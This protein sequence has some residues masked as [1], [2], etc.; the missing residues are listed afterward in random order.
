MKAVIY[1]R[2]STLLKQDP[3]HQLIPARELVNHRGYELVKEYT[4]RISGSSDKRE[5]LDQLI[6]DARSGK[7]KIVVIYALDRIARDTRF[8]LNLIHEL[9]SY[10]VSLISLRESIDLSTPIGRA[11]LQILGSI[12]E[13]ERNLISERIKTALAVK[14]MKADKEKNGWRCGR[15]PKITSELVDAV[16]KLRDSGNSIRNTAKV[17]NISKTTVLRICQEV[18]KPT[19]EIHK[20]FVSENSPKNG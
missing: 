4:D 18:Q 8:L 6:K 11:L 10:G 20:M 12:A 16:I 9:E 14:K 15:P 17:L 5:G 1:A 19:S 13:L 3:N 7:F 2:V